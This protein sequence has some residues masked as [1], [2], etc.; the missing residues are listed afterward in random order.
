MHHWQ[1]WWD[2]WGTVCGARQCFLVR[3]EFCRLHLVVK[4]ANVTA[5]LTL[6]TSLRV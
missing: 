3:A 4:M 5:V 2:A 6:F 1:L